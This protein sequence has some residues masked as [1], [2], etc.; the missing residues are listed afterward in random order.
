VP[1]HDQQRPAV[2]APGV[3][4]DQRPPL[5]LYQVQ[6]ARKITRQR[7]IG[8]RL[9]GAALAQGQAGQEHSQHPAPRS[10]I[11]SHGESVPPILRRV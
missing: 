5:H 1:C 3:T 2:A 10:D 8:R 7:Y 4:G 9:P 11:L 6:A